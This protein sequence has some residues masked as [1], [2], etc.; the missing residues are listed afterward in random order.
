MNTDVPTKR[1][2]FRVQ[3]LRDVGV[4]VDAHE[5]GAN[6][7]AAACDCEHRVRTASCSMGVAT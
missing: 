5:A 2:P 3:D 6:P 7:A 4:A 1:N